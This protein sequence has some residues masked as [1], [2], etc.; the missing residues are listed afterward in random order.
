MI[1]L[2]K[3]PLRNHD[4][5]PRDFLRRHLEDSLSSEINT[6]TWHQA[7]PQVPRIESPKKSIYA[8]TL[9]PHSPQPNIA[10]V[11]EKFLPEVAQPDFAHMSIMRGPRFVTKQLGRLSIGCADNQDA[12][13]PENAAGFEEEQLMVRDMFN[14]LEAQDDIRACILKGKLGYVS[15]TEVKATRTKLAPGVPNWGVVVVESVDALCDFG[16]HTSTIPNAGS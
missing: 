1:G 4:I 14:D 13:G 10:K 16:N 12:I 2:P 3:L 6:A 15:N 5:L 9:Q 11:L 7:K 8:T